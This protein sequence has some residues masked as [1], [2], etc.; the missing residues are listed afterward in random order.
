MVNLTTTSVNSFLDS[1]ESCDSLE[2][3]INK[4]RQLEAIKAALIAAK[5][6]N[7]RSCLYARLEAE[8]LIKV[9]ELGGEKE[10]KGY[11]RK[12]AV[13]LF[14]MPIDERQGIVSQCGEGITLAQL[15]KILVADEEKLDRD[16]E[17]ANIYKAAAIKE[18]KD[19][20]IVDFDR[21]SKWIREKVAPHDPQL[22]ADMVDGLRAKLREE[23]G[24]GTREGV[25]VVA[26]I[27]NYNHVVELRKALKTKLENIQAVL[28]S[29]EEFSRITG[30]RLY[31]EDIKD[32]L[33]G[34]A[35]RSTDYIERIIRQPSTYDFFNSWGLLEQEDKHDQIT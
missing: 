27:E 9:I 25:Y 13:W 2:E 15:F 30:V 19:S 8:A 12:A 1:I 10:L 26:D 16:V 17:M 29:M 14:E 20:G 34:G 18:L 35:K 22:A 5:R 28:Y 21:Y 11:K 31:K 7:E 3:I 23:G 32:C 6:F 24:H 33:R 4:I